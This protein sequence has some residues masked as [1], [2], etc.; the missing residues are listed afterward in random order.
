MGVLR[1]VG[2]ALLGAA[3]APSIAGADSVA[4]VWTAPGDDG[5]AGRASSYEL[6]YSENP[7]AGDTVSWWSSA[8]SIGT[9]QAPLNAGSRESF[10]VTGLAP[11]K[12]Y[13]FVIRASDEIPNV[14]GYS[15]VAVK[16]TSGSVTLATP[17]NFG[18]SATSRA[19]LLTWDAVPAG[20]P[21]LGYRLYR[22]ASGDPAQTLLTTL[23]FSATSWQDSTVTAGTRYDF[24]L[25][26]YNDSGEGTPATIN[27]RVPKNASADK[28]PVAHGYPNPAKTQVTFRLSVS[29]TSSEPT[30]VT[31]FDLTGHR[32]CQLLDEVLAPGEHAVPWSLHSDEGC[33]VAPGIYNVIVDGPSGR[34]V[35][36]LAI[37]P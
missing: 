12:T 23:A 29:A 11:G 36:R 34:G 2:A 20:G 22:Q 8:A 37:V 33:K 13:Y 6:R 4:L 28:K 3:L 32:I 18:A 19:V 35:S 7:T 10:I 24:R 21:E 9:M 17:A 5:N 25:A 15:N 16:Q 31:V 14:S 30:K 1:T 26:T 27:V